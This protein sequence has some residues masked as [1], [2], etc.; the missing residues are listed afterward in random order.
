MLA[1]IIHH[2]FFHPPTY[3]L[4]RYLWSPLC[5]RGWASEKAGTASPLLVSTGGGGLKWISTH[6]DVFVVTCECMQ[7]RKGVQGED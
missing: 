7:L 5:A 1:I 6:T 3:S 4:S 2:P